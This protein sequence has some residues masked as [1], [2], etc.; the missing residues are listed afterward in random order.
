MLPVLTSCAYFSD[1]ASHDKMAAPVTALSAVASTNGIHVV[2][3]G[4]TLY[5]IAWKYGR[6]YRSLA[7]TNQISSPYTIYPGQKL[8]LKR[9]ADFE[10]QS[11]ASTYKNNIV[12]RNATISQSN[13]E[14]KAIA[15][16]TTPKPANKTAETHF[17]HEWSWPVKGKIL[18]VFS[19]QGLTPNKG[20]DIAG[21]MGAP[22]S[23]A[24][25]G[26]VVYSGSGLRGYGQLL[27]IKHN[28]TFLSAYAHNSRLLVKEG[29]SVEKGQ[30]IAH[31]GQSEAQ[32]VRLHFEIR[33]NG[34]PINPLKLLPRQS[35]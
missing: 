20:I 30:L 25:K 33:K 12:V 14:P 24:G 22:V 16:T 8:T 5:E 23:A 3:R 32:S 34:Q 13:S 26:K 35:V 1:K 17:N 6:D 19:T 4:E 7:K 2:Q 9:Y 15:K 28:E 27:I 21:T 18:N 11:K 29:D 10:N 31:M